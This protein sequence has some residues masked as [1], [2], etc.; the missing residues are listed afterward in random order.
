MPRDPGL[1]TEPLLVSFC[2]KVSGFGGEEEGAEEVAGEAPFPR[3]DLA[4]SFIF[5]AMVIASCWGRAGQASLT[6]EVSLAMIWASSCGVVR[7]FFV[8]FLEGAA[9][10]PL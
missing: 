7:G 6:V 10:C 1:R 4:A 2:R 9:V 5:I 8:F 3:R